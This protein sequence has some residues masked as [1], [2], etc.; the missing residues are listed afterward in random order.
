MLK[1]PAPRLRV[2]RY[3]SISLATLFTVFVFTLLAHAEICESLTSLKLPKTTIT[4]SRVEEGD[5]SSIDQRHA[6][7]LK[8]TGP[9]AA[10]SMRLY[11]SPGME[12]CFGGD[13]PS[14][15]DLDA[16]LAAWVEDHKT[17][18]SIPPLTTRPGRPSTQTAPAP[19][20]LTRRSQ[21]SRAPAA[22]TMQPT[23]PAANPEFHACDLK[24]AK[25]GCQAP[26]KPHASSKPM[27][28]SWFTS[29]NK[30]SKS[31]D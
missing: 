2:T 6:R 15:F 26:P 31:A 20:V 16:P 27:K 14:N 3:T 22:P 1:S 25:N 21:G 19:S 5:L 17:P 18:E 9:A 10:N 30:P 23:L 28:I 12:H 11:L 7:W 29:K 24:A 8:A 4:L 13:C